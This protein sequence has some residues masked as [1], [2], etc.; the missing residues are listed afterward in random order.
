MEKAD[1]E[2]KNTDNLFVLRKN[3]DFSE[4]ERLDVEPYSYWKSVARQF[5]S[6]KSAIFALIILVIMVI[7]SIVVPMISDY[8]VLGVDLEHRYLTPSLTYLF[9][10]DK[11]GRDIWT[12]VWT[13]C[14]MSLTIAVVVTLINT[15]LGIIIGG[16]WGYFRKLDP[17]MLEIYNF[18]TNIPAL[19]IYMMLLY[20]LGTLGT[21]PFLNLVIAMCITG[22]APLARLIR[23]QMIIFNNREYNIASRALGSSPKRIIVNNLLPY[24][25]SVII[26]NVS[27]S[28]SQVIGTE[29]TL[30]YFGLGLPQDTISL[31]RIMRQAYNS[32][33]AHP[34]VLIFPAIV[35]GM[36]TIVFYLL[37]LAL[38]DALDPRT[39]R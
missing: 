16:I 25:L 27:L 38:S 34:H 21:P 2:K 33:I 20:V 37:G 3:N 10:T 32:W 14:R 19:L 18:I 13:G 1:L 28:I 8:D 7:L 26:T 30:S 12:L 22:W 4:S 31:G 6:K 39:H 15:F 24:I 29:V 17:L 36:I 9:G 23:N 35:V 5:A 11:S